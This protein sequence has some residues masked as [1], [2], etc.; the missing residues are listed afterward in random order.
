MRSSLGAR[1][2]Y[3]ACLMAITDMNVLMLMSM[4]A[5][6]DREGW[7][8]MGQVIMAT[9]TTSLDMILDEASQEL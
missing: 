1:R 9:C 2:V 7:V 6:K 4:G 5:I 3:I 8:W